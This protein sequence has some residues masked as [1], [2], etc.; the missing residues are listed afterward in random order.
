MDRVKCYLKCHILTRGNIGSS[1]NTCEELC[2]LDNALNII[3]I[4]VGYKPTL[5]MS[6]CRAVTWND[7]V[8]CVTIF[9][10]KM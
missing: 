1:I 3:C 7:R 5:Y 4:R 6:D 9:N 8:V 10:Y 2:I